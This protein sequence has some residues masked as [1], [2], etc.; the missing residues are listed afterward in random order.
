MMSKTESVVEEMARPVTDQLGLELVDVEF[1]KEG[2]NWF[3]RVFIDKPEGITHEDCQAVSEKIS[4][5]LDEKD[6]IEQ[7]YFLEVSSPGIERPLKK[8]ADFE[9]Y[10]DSLVNISTFMPIEGQKTFQGKLQGVEEGSVVITVN[11]KRLLIPFDKISSARL[12]IEF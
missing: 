11:Q 12:A 6:P 7:N 4:D 8:V 2:G 3:L 10:R 9:K 5:L 1:K